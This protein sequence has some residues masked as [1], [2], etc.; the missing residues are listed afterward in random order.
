MLIPGK[1]YKPL[2]TIFALEVDGIR[3]KQIYAVEFNTYNI[4]LFLKIL[5]IRSELFTNLFL[6]NNRFYIDNNYAFKNP[7]K[8][9]KEL[10]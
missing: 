8:Y 7:T 9:Y 6:F 2:K 5:E 3:I 1:L 4:I 10:K